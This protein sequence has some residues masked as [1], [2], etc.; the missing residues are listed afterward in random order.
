[1]TADCVAEQLLTKRIALTG[2][3]RAFVGERG[4]AEDLFQE[5]TVRAIASAPDFADDRHLHRWFR[6]V[7]KH[8]AI[9]HL[10][11]VENRRR[12]FEADVIELLADEPGEGDVLF[13]GGGER[14]AALEACLETLTPKCREVIELRYGEEL[15]GLEVAERLGRKPDTVYK[16]LARSYA[17]LRQCIE[18][19]MAKAPA[20]REGASG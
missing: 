8:R 19:R 9:D 20:A 7:A 18:T 11:K 12:V 4:T 5:V 1:M 14:C 17:H 16:M 13:A 15:P 6:K 2:Y 3:L 10:R